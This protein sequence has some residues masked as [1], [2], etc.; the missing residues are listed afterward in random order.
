MILTNMIQKEVL[1]DEIKSW[2]KRALALAEETTSA[3]AVTSPNT[4]AAADCCGDIHHLLQ[5]NNL[6]VRLKMDFYLDCFELYEILK[7]DS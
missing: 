4:L 2:H 6:E 3:G 7:Y 5:I 1:G